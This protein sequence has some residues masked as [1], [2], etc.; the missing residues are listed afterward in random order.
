[1]STVRRTDPETL[2]QHLPAAA[3]PPVQD[4]LRELAVPVHVV[5]PRRSKLG[6]YWMPRDGRPPKITVNN[7]LNPYA[8]LVTLVH[9]FAHH[10]TWLSAKRAEPH[11][12][13]W[14]REYQRLMRP[15][16]SPAVLPP[17]VHIALEGHLRR[18]PASSC[19][20]R[21]LMRT[22]LRHENEPVLV[23]ERLP[24]RSLFQFNGAVY[25]KGPR[26]RKRYKCRCL[27][28]HRIY[29]MDPLIEVLVHDP[30]VVGP[31]S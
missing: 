5:K 17:D 21:S 7:D 8:F 23:L 18:A 14:R 3:W 12:A 13:E 26:M 9:E 15:F 16:L 24:E 25:V 22:L 31:A 10:T 19:T 20:D 2:R 1:M 28:N 27:N 4:L 30:A 11:G 6:D 29:I